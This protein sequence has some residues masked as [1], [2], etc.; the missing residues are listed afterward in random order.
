MATPFTSPA[1]LAISISRTYRVEFRK[2]AVSRT[3]QRY[4][5]KKAAASEWS[6]TTLAPSPD[7][8]LS[9][10]IYNAVEPT[11]YNQKRAGRKE[12]RKAHLRPQVVSPDLCDDILGS[13]G[14]SLKNYKGCD[15]LD[16]NPGA[17]LWS[18]KIHDF[19]QPRSHILLEPEPE[20][21]RK[22]LDPLIK[23]PGSKYKLVTGDTN[24]F[25]IFR[26]L[27]DSNFFPNQKKI[28]LG[29][30]R[31]NDLNETLLVTG[32][33][34]W[35]PMLPGFGFDSMGK[36]LLFKHIV[37]SR[38]NDIFHEFGKIR[39]LIWLRKDDMKMVMPRTV[40]M[41]QKSNIITQKLAESNEI[42]TTG[43]STRGAG[44]DAGSGRE[45][46]YELESLVR[47]FKAMK[48]K[49]TKL[50]LRRREDIHDF[51]D[52]ISGK[53]DGKGQMT[54]AECHKY[55]REQHNQGKSAGGLIAQKTL[56]IW[57]FDRL[58]E[59]QPGLKYDLSR[60]AARG[61][62]SHRATD[63]QNEITKSRAQ[64]QAVLRER[65]KKDEAADIGEKIYHLECRILGMNDGPEKEASQELLAQLQNEFQQKVGRIKTTYRN[66]VYNDIDDRINI[67]SD[68]SRMLWDTRSF[69][70]L[71]M[72]PD[73]AWPASGLGL[74]NI[75]PKPTSSTESNTDFEY[76]QD[77]VLALFDLPSEDLVTALE[78]M[79]AGASDLIAEVP[80]LR[81]PAQGG[82]LD[83]KQL[84]VRMLT[85]EMVDELCA[86]FHAWPFKNPEASHTNYFKTRRGGMA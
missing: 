55:L 75:V 11:I 39:M 16:I 19:L 1:R 17:G 13:Y 59:T 80:R 24:R 81:N 82:R 4:V 68:I 20:I 61:P 29:D 74:A 43:H 10:E 42:V 65:I 49:G 27:I 73:E 34:T 8:P 7:Y 48:S 23:K 2:T 21:W 72:R 53:T 57:D 56:E 67:R 50:P 41:I 52:D 78:R 6:K 63:A 69:E 26:E 25:E 33:F 70:P 79:Q 22:F 45:P 15:I 5:R 83:M 84:R 44:R 38:Y 35:E 60:P 86:A 14:D 32:S 76:L 3:Q 12:Y 37:L 77:F 64:E 47:A 62:T 28:P 18:R 30:P 36:Q 66:Q 31:V 58:A 9:Q 71:V 46:R 85:V 40:A 54:V 51:A